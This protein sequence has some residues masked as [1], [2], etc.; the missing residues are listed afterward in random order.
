MRCT[1]SLLLASAACLFAASAVSAQAPAAGP[2][3]SGA[4]NAAVDKYGCDTSSFLQCKDG[5]WELQNSCLPSN[6][7]DIPAY[8]ALC[9]QNSQTGAAAGGTPSPTPAVPSPAPNV[10]P[11]GSS[12]A[13]GPAATA[14]GTPKPSTSSSSSPSPSSDP[15]SNSSAAVI[16][17]A[18]DGGSSHTGAIVGGIIGALVLLALILAA[19]FFWRRRQASSHESMPVPSL[20]RPAAY[21]ATGKAQEEGLAMSQGASSS[22]AGLTAAGLSVASVLEKKYVVRHEYQPAAE[23]EVQLKVGDRIRMD[24][25]FNDGWAKGTNEST[26][27]QGLLPVACLQEA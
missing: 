15:N 8:A 9:G 19:I 27:Q 25:L 12:A 23:D 20:A 1:K 22:S 6:C 13:P 10:P 2:R 3:L 26:G 21:A 17:S 18:A 16:A 14:A 5:V 11:P 7:V 4:C 24:L